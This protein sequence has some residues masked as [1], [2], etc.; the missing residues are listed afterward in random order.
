MTVPIM[1]GI[2]KS[3]RDRYICLVKERKDKE[4]SDSVSRDIFVNW[5]RNTDSSA[6]R[7]CDSSEL[8]ITD[9]KN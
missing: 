3:V 2:I 8:Y 7:W 9:V 1:W 4:R 6:V 5:E